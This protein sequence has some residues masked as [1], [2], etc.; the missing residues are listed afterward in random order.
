MIWVLVNLPE[1]AKAIPCKWVYWIKTNPD[2]GINKYKIRLAIKG[3][4]QCQGI[5]YIE[6]FSPVAK[7]ET[8]WAMRSW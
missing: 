2:G 1:G 8:M 5:D 3:Y 6:T 4:S 7:L